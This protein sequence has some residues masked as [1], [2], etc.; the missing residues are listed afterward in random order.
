[1]ADSIYHPVD[2]AGQRHM[3]YVNFRGEFDEIPRDELLQV[4]VE[5]YLR[6]QRL[7]TASWE[8]DV[9]VEGKG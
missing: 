8:Q 6:M 2:L 5:H 1:M 3:A 7:D 4:F 9:A